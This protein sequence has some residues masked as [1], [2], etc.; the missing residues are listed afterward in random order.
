MPR[1]VYPDH[2]LE[3][4]RE[5][6]A[7]VQAAAGRRELHNA[8]RRHARALDALNRAEVVCPSCRR[9]FTPKRSDA[10]YCSTACRVAAHRARGS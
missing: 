3:R 2:L 7:A 10:I 4:E 8:R 5:A 9:P 1:R 6:H